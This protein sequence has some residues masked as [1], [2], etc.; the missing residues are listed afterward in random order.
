MN[1][2]LSR[3]RVLFVAAGLCMSIAACEQKDVSADALHKANIQ[4]ASLSPFGTPAGSN[5]FKVQTYSEVIRSLQPVSR[6]GSASQKAAASLLIAQS[7]AG[8]AEPPATNAGECE[9]IVL[10]SLSGIRSRLDVFLTQSSSAAASASYDPSKEIADIEKSDKEKAEHIKAEQAKKAVIDKKVA[11]L[12]AQAQA[13]ADQ[14]RALR[15]EVGK[16]RQ[17][18]P[19]QTATEGEKTLLKARELTRRADALEVESASLDAEASHTAPQAVEGQNSIERL[20][21]QRELL[22]KERGEIAKRAQ[23]AKDRSAKDR[24]DAAKTAD[25]IKQA[26]TKIEEIRNGDL[27][28]MTEQ[29]VKGYTDASTAAKAAASEMKTTAQMTIGAANQSLADVQLARAQGLQSFAQ[30]LDTLATAKPALPDAAAYKSKSDEA[31]AAAKEAVEAARESYKTADAAYNA[32]GATGEAKTRLEKINR[33]LRDLVKATGGDPELIPSRGEVAPETP[34]PAE[35]TPAT[36]ADATGG[37][38]AT[39]QA[40]I[41]I[42]ATGNLEK[43]E[44]WMLWNNEDDRKVF[45]SLVAIIPAA[46]RLDA[47]AK[48][49]FGQ[50][51]PMGLDRMASGPMKIFQGLKVSDVKFTVTGDTAVADIPGDP[52]P[53]KLKKQGDK[54]LIDPE[55]LPP[56]MKEMASAMDAMAKSLNSI[57]ADVE[58]GKIADMQAFGIAVQQAMAPFMAKMMP[59]G[60]G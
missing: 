3:V 5:K 1:Q 40:V 56:E 28:T 30:A 32:A 26:V 11:D 15:Q 21:K 29:A 18:I 12:K 9:R 31:K 47:A 46:K 51:I 52:E 16:D 50:S 53:T 44:D 36:T 25:E 45:K 39:I 13:K 54:W 43:M 48:A 57:A 4:L 33:R 27:K 41:D 6:E 42:V 58:S 23:I 60:G 8:L 37:P 20:N 38:Q 7:Q 55:A 17:K 19:N 22:A 35:A 24:A 34:P 14:A 49:K 2:V 10:N 59:P